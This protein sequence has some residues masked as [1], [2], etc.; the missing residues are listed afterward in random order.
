MLDISE[1]SE[2]I[3]KLFPP[4]ST[5]TNPIVVNILCGVIN[6]NCGFD[7]VSC[8]GP[9]LFMATWNETNLIGPFTIKLWM[10]L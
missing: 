10:V 8:I 1:R 9:G 5:L 2:N 7:R 3:S 4:Y 6:F